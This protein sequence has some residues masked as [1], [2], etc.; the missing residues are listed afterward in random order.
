MIVEEKGL[1]QVE[2]TAKGKSFHSSE[3]FNG[4]NAIEKLITYYEEL[5]KMFPN[6]TK[7][8]FKTTVNLSIINGGDAY[9]KVPDSASMILDIR[10]NNDYNHNKLIS[11][12]NNID[13]TI[14]VKELD[15]G[16]T[17]QCNINNKYIKKFIKDGETILNRKIKIV[18]ACSTGDCI[19][20]SEKNIPTIM[21]NPKVYNLHS[22]NEHV[23]ISSLE[24]L[25]ELFK[26]LL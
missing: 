2:I 12:L 16:P 4:I 17:F 23:I 8:E 11:I 5:I 13:K 26:T 19:Y 21:I 20:F 22:D 18:K 24:K 6:S 9:N 15:Y 14:E 7:E 25:Y 3:P 10:F 1:L